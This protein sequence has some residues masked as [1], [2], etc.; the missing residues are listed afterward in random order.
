MVQVPDVRRP[1]R[2]E[3]L[4][5][6]TAALVL[7]LVGGLGLS[8]VGAGPAFAA[9]DEI[10]SYDITYDVQAS[11]VVKVQETL[12]YRFGS[13]GRHGIDRILVTREKYDDSSDAVYGVS[14]IKVSS[15]DR[16]STEFATS[17]TDADSGREN[18]LRIRIGDPDRT[19]SVDSATY[20]ISYDL[21]GA[22][23]TFSGYDEFYWDATGLEDRKSVV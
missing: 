14:N 20:V 18:S 19:L 4:V 12:D 17:T 10:S 23:R 16:V 13:S 11:G 22:M 5:R 9:G 3:R 6:W 2:V 1:T 21:T 15:P 7:A 8:Q